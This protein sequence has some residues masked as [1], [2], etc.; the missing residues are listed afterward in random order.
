MKILGEQFVHSSHVQYIGPDKHDAVFVKVNQYLEDGSVR[1]ALKKIYRPKRKFWVTKK[2]MQSVYNE[3]KEWETIQNLDEYVTYNDQLT[4]EAFK[5]LNG[6]HPNQFISLRQLS[7]SPYL[8]GTDISVESLIKYQMDK[9]FNETGLTKRGVTSGGFDTE[10]SMFKDDFGKLI[11][12]T[13]T[14]EELVYTSV[15]RSFFKKDTTSTDDEIIKNIEGYIDRILK[16]QKK[17]FPSK[18]AQ[19]AIGD[20]QFKYHIH[21]ADTPIDILRYTL[22]NLHKNKTD[23][24]TIWNIEFDIPVILRTCEQA[25]VDPS[26]IFSPEEVPKEYR[27]FLFKVD[28]GKHG[29]IS[30]RRWHWLYGP[31]Y[32][33]WIDA[34]CLYSILRI[35][36]GYENNY[37]LDYILRKNKVSDGKLK[38]KEEIPSANEMSTADW[39]RF[40]QSEHPYEYILYG[41]FDVIGMQV[42][43]WINHDIASMNTLLKYTP[44]QNFNKQTRRSADEI[45]FYCINMSPMHVPAATA[46]WGDDG[47]DIAKKGGA[48]LPAERAYRAGAN[49]LREALFRETHVH[50]HVNDIDFSALYPNN[51]MMCNVS[52]ETKRAMILEIEGFSRED[53]RSYLSQYLAVEENAIPMCHKYFNLPNYQE[54]D[55][56]FSE[57]LKGDILM[58]EQE[59]VS[60]QMEHTTPAHT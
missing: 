40:M 11:M 41:I 55:Q 15:L 3:K 31:S 7:K 45:H 58:L 47:H 34:M 60:I 52:R 43:G 9:K 5:A 37:S 6:F 4:T 23:Y 59:L 2:G 42:L 51:D 20:R 21:I 36:S 22:G 19:K 13:I 25:G 32:T 14:H 17:I 26:E 16:D 35:V 57:H 49:V 46:A 8:Y 10:T 33:Q 56:A 29:D 12:A 24:M 53:V 50:P 44:C 27:K 54:M 39:H 30:S 38:F 1:P 18:E 28:K 48:V